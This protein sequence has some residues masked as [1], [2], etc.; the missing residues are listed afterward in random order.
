[1]TSGIANGENESFRRFL[2]EQG[3]QPS[4]SKHGGQKNRIHFTDEATN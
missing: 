1:M 2:Y 4:T 3:R